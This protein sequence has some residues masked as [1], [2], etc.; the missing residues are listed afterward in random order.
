MTDEVQIYK[1]I[2]LFSW[3]EKFNLDKELSRWVSSFESKFGKDSINIYN[4]ENRDDWAI[5]QSIFW[6][7]LFSTKKLTI[8]KWLPLSAKKDWLPTNIVEPFTEYIIANAQNIPVDNL[9]I[10][11]S[12]EPDKRGRFFKFLQSKCSF[13]EFAKLTPLQLKQF[14]NSNFENF[15]ISDKVIE[16]FINTVWDDLYRIDSECDKLKTYCQS[17]NIEE[18][19]QDIVD[20]VTFWMTENNVFTF[21][22]LAYKDRIQAIKYLQKI[23]D[24]D[25]NRNMFA[26]AL[27]SQLRTSIIINRCYQKWIKKADD[28]AKA[29]WL[30]PRA[31]FANL[32][33]INDISKNWIALE[34]MYKLLVQTDANIKSGKAEE[35]EFWLN[36]KKAI[37]EFK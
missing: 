4:S 3:P 23:Q 6:W 27:Y 33:K 34:N 5:K 26:W 35:I 21:L 14:I 32:N 15:K 37:M 8:I 17:K 13:K 24:E 30:N 7:W 11:V 36:T 31:V 12:Y 22:D 2:F 29:S 19:T 9:L 18:I 20:K 1:N 16:Q 10:F 25:L 28:I